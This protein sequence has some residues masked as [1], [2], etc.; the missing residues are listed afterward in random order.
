M[1]GTMSRRGFFTFSLAAGAA[2]AMSQPALA[3]G[4][5]DP[6]DRLTPKKRRELEEQRRKARERRKQERKNTKR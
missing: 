1:S 5:P 2:V 3:R 6:E 4:G